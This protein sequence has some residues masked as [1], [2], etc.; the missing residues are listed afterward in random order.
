MSQPFSDDFWARMYELAREEPGRNAEVIHDGLRVVVVQDLDDADI[1]LRKRLANYPKNLQWFAQVGGQSR[2][3]EDGDQWRFRSELSQPSFSRYD[4]DRGYA[5]SAKQTRRMAG[6]LAANTKVPLLDE[7]VIHHCILSIFTE[8]FLDVELDKIPIAHDGPSRL[9]ELA[10][11][12]TCIHRGQGQDAHTKD[13]IRQILESRRQVFGSMQCLRD[14]N[15]YD[16]A[17]MRRMLAAEAVPGYDFRFEKEMTT[18]FV[19]GADTAS[20]STGWALHLLASYPE[21]Q[22]RLHTGQRAIHTSLPDGTERC[23]AILADQDLKAF[24]SEL[25]RLHSPLPF[26]T[27]VAKADDRLSNIDVHAR[28]VVIVSLIGVNRKAMARPDPWVPDIDAAARE[29]VGMG[30]GINSSFT[31]GARV[32]GGRSFALLELTT[33]LSF[34]IAELHFGLSENLPIECEWVGQMRRKGGHRITSSVRK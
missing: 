24:I 26:V 21:L 33:I 8:M 15:A 28:D 4:H 23:R 6:L 13:H 19:A 12:Y 9:I 22:E 7:D 11:K 3:T 27:R 34:L 31:W 29:G 17:M 14:G 1:V 16:S 10:S 5:I 32:C 30:T 25:L 2:L 20:N 18:L